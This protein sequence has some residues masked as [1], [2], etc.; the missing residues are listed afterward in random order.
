MLI[1]HWY[2]PVLLLIEER[3]KGSLIFSSTDQ[4]SIATMTSGLLSCRYRYPV[5]I[6]VVAALTLLFVLWHEALDPLAASPAATVRV[7]AL[8]KVTRAAS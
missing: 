7:R 1:K 8:K 5:V 3:E 4:V 6:V 2:R